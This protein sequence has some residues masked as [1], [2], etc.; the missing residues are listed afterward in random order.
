ME[1]VLLSVTNAGHLML[2]DFAILAT[3]DTILSTD[4][5]FIL[6]QTMPL[7]LMLAARSGTGLPMPVRFA[8]LLGIL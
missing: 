6:L 8:H 4:P 3:E 7:F 5:V 1:S 2:R